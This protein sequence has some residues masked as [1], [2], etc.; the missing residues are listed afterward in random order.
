MKKIITILI[1]LV[2]ILLVITLFSLDFGTNGNGN[3]G[4]GNN[5]SSRVFLT[6]TFSEGFEDALSFED[7]FDEDL[8]R[9]HNLHQE[10]SSNKLEINNNIVHSG[11]NSLKFFS[12]ARTSDVP[13]ASIMRQGFSFK[14]NDEVWSSAWYYIEG[15]ANAQ[16]TFLW[17]LEDSEAYQNP[18]RRI[19]I[20]EGEFIASDL[21]KSLSAEIFR[22]ERGKEIKVPKNKW[23]N[24]KI[25]LY[26]SEEKDGRME[27]WQDNI[28]IINGKGQTLPNKNSIYDRLEVGLTANANEESTRTLYLDDIRISDKEF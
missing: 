24:I 28:K 12:V 8:S 14:K 6:N 10:P 11:K 20:Q 4:N 3:N 23:F 13:K 16:D 2:G 22:Q 15:N 18:G 9:W 21:G 17:D 7:I 5:N 26:L 1:V 25:Y 19:Y 27:V